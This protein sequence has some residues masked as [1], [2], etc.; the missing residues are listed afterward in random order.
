MD[1]NETLNIPNVNRPIISYIIEPKEIESFDSDVI[2]D[3]Y[4]NTGS[5]KGSLKG[6]IDGQQD[7]HDESQE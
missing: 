3:G 2:S 6:E 4:E 7:E 5:D 1:E